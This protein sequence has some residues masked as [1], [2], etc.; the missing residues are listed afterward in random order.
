ML[1]YNHF[2]RATASEC[3]KNPYFDDIRILGLEKPCKMKINLDHFQYHFDNN[4]LLNK[5]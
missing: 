2:Y 3:V 5:K 4:F 1:E